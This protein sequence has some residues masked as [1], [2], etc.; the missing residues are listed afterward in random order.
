MGRIHLNTPL[1]LSVEEGLHNSKVP[2]TDLLAARRALEGLPSVTLLDDW[3]WNTEVGKWVLHCQISIGIKSNELI[4]ESSDWYVLVDQNYPFGDIKFHPAKVNGIDQTFPH[5]NNN[6]DW[7]K[8]VPWRSG[9]ICL[10]TGLYILKRHNQQDLEPHEPHSRLYWYCQ[11][12]GQWLEAA[13][14]NSLALPNE[15]FELPHFPLMSGTTVCF[16]EDVA[17]FKCWETIPDKCGSVSLTYLSKYPDI[18][19]VKAFQSYRGEDLLVP[20]WGKLMNAIKESSVKGIWLRMD[21]IPILKP[22]QAPTTWGELRRVCREQS[23][24][25]DN[26][27]EPMVKSLRDGK[28]HFILIGFP[29]PAKVGG[30]SSQLHW[31]ALE[32][33]ALS[34]GTN[35]AKGFRTNENGYWQRDRIEILDRNSRVRWVKTENWHS[36]QISTRGKL[37]EALTNAKILLLGSGA[38][39]SAIAELLVRGSTHKLAI[40]DSDKLCIGNLTRH[41]LDLR[42]LSTSKAMGLAE[43]LNVIS[44]NVTVDAFSDDFP[45]TSEEKRSYLQSFEVILDCTGDDSVIYHLE[46]FPWGCTKVFVSL[47]LGIGGKRLFCFIARGENFPSAVFRDLLNPW[48]LKELKEKSAHNLPREGIGCWHPVFPARSDDVWMMCSAAIKYI[49]TWTTKNHPSSELVVFEQIYEDNNFM[50]IRIL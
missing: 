29:I 13:S 40:L 48:L 17:S 46:H 15:P 32:I 28:A 31:Q 35:T 39:G 50:G 11:R 16:S 36:D 7:D 4:P 19:F 2:S 44:P 10:S 21:S 38:V 45:C 23:V 37:P 5:Q 18:L 1:L 34:S 47:S 43:R 12:A 33:P 20:T 22:W 49:E 26:L 27:L 25:I 30:S 8:R 42:Y 41:T 24:E 6:T 3:E 14:Q 9:D